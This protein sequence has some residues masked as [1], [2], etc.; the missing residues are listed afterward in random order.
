MT[1]SRYAMSWKTRYDRAIAHASESRVL[2]S[3][4]H[5]VMRRA[6]SKKRAAYHG[7]KVAYN[8]L[9]E[10]PAAGE[11]PWK[12]TCVALV[13]A[14]IDCKDHAQAYVM[15][16]FFLTFPWTKGHKAYVSE[17]LR[18]AMDRCRD[19]LGPKWFEVTSATTFKVFGKFQKK[20]VG[21]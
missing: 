6:K 15:A 19:A 12:T 11:L 2:T 18:I 8:L 1:K 20:P 3:Q 21:F 10:S 14:A 16:E 17:R 9:T 7:L 5:A 13:Y 4:A